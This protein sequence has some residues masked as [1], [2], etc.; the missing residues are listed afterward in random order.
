MTELTQAQQRILEVA[1]EQP[2]TDIRQ[3]MTYIK[4]PA[5]QDKLL[6]ALLTRGLII[7]DDEKVAFVISA[8]GLAAIGKAVITEPVAPKISKQ[9]IVIELLSTSEGATLAS[10]QEATGWQAHTVRGMISATLKKKLGLSIVSSQ[11]NG[12]RVYKISPAS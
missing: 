2:D 10:I 4:S 9:Q 5:I 3:F 8:K 7:Q 12:E 1:S 11:I 6:T